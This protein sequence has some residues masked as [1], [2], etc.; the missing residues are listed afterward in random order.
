VGEGFC[1]GKQRDDAGSCGFA[2]A[3]LVEA[4]E[5]GFDFLSTLAP[6]EVRAA[7]PAK[8]LATSVATPSKYPATPTATSITQQHPETSSNSSANESSNIHLKCHHR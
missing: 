1:R 8:H 5:A 2:D 6:D 4:E 7:T 3:T